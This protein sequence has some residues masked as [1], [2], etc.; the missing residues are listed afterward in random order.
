MLT[1]PGLATK[2]LYRIEV[3]GQIGIPQ[4]PTAKD[5]QG[6]AHC[7]IDTIAPQLQDGLNVLGCMNPTG[8]G[9]GK[10]GPLAQQ[11]DQRRLNASAST[12]DIHGMDQIFGT[13]SGQRIQKAVINALVCECLPTV[14]DDKITVVPAAAAQIQYQPIRPHKLGQFSQAVL[15]HLTV[16]KNPRGN[17]DGGCASVQP[18]DSIVNGNTA[19]DLH[20]QRPGAE[21]RL[22]RLTISRPKLDDMAPIN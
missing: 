21:C 9:H 1:K 7:E 17:N 14:G 22:R 10:L 20:P 13:I 8:V 18:L 3:P 11:L 6:A 12:L 4:S 16:V 19:T 2:K 5:I 15:I